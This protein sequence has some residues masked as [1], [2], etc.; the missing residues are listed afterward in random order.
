M[1]VSL[2]GSVRDVKATTTPSAAA[3]REV[4]GFA[5]YETRRITPSDIK[6]FGGTNQT[7]V[8]VRVSRTTAPDG[9][10]WFRLHW[11][12]VPWKEKPPSYELPVCALRRLDNGQQDGQ[13]PN[14][15]FFLCHGRTWGQGAS[16]KRAMQSAAQLSRARIGAIAEA[17]R[18][19]PAHKC[20]ETPCVA[21]ENAGRMHVAFTKPGV[22]ADDGVI[23][24]AVE[25]DK[26]DILVVHDSICTGLLLCKDGNSGLQVM[27]FTGNGVTTGHFESMVDAAEFVSVARFAPVSILHC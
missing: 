25:H 21:C 11:D 22:P 7:M 3:L 2:S 14:A 19:P 8:Q 20:T 23:V 6:K 1:S 12:G 5:S 10:Q 24:A 9:V 15:C 27:Y 4:V 17:L 13:G 16:Q 18:S 26:M